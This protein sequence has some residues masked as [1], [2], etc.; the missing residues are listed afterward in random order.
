MNTPPSQTP[1]N[2]ACYPT[3]FQQVILEKSQNF[4]DRP[5]IFTAISD[6]LHRHK[7]GY[8]TIVGVPGSGKSAILAK[9]ATENS[10]V[11]Y[12][13]AQVEGKNRAEEFLTTV[14]NNLVETLHITSLQDET[15]LHPIPDNATEGSWFLSLLLQKISDTRS[16]KPPAYRL[17]PHQRLIIAIDALDAIDR[18]SQPPGTNLFYLP[19]YLPN[20]IYFILTR[21]P[22]KREKSGLLIEAPSQI[23]DLSEYPEQNREDVQAYIRQYLTPS[24]SPQ[25]ERGVESGDSSH[26]R[27]EELIARLTTESENNFMYLHYLFNAIAEGFYSEPYQFDRIPPGLEAYYQQHWQKIKG[28]GLSD[29]ALKVLDVLTSG[30]TGGMSA[31]AITQIIH[32]DEY[33]V[34]EILENWLEFL[35]QGVGKETTYSLYHSHFRV[36]LAKQTS[37]S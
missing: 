1:V 2:S 28:E 10:N 22:F 18:N 21:R 33:D 19:R 3:Q 16:V 26:I 4:I 29:V 13:N 32:E 7:R 14:C 15:S 11:V 6:F 30:E 20:G 9:Y 17:E 5:F 31:K 27:E 35:Q 12:Y 24:P 23:L 34:A 37:N 25:A 8:F 36:W